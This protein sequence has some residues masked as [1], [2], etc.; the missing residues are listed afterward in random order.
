L[1]KSLQWTLSLAGVAIGLALPLSTQGFGHLSAA[2]IDG[3]VRDSSLFRKFPLG[4]A[5]EF[6]FRAEAF[7]LLSNVLGQPN[8]GSE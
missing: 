2:S 3:I 7:N 8:N 4:E 1:Q 6:E 5:R